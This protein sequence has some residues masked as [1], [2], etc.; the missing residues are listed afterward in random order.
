MTVEELLNEIECRRFVMI[1]VYR[2]VPSYISMNGNTK[3]KLNKIELFHM[4]ILIDDK[5]ADDEFRLLRK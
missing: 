4:E 1:Q 3:L 5:L 2:K